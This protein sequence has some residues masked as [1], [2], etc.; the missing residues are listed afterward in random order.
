V[1]ALEAGAIPRNGTT[2]GARSQ[3]GSATFFPDAPHTY[4]CVSARPL[5][6]R[7]SDLL[8]SPFRRL[9]GN[10]H[11]DLNGDECGS[12]RCSREAE[13][14][15]GEPTQTRHC[16]CHESWTENARGRP[17]SQYG[18]DRGDDAETTRRMTLESTREMVWRRRESWCGDDAADDVGDDTGTIRPMKPQRRG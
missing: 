18:R 5:S 13:K 2:G 17:A 9:S 1:G 11:E 16:T 15:N 3:S 7:T 10:H 12:R 4:V 6:C 14:T 8:W